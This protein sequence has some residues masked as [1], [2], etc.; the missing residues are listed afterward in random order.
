MVKRLLPHFA[1]V[2][3]FSL[4]T[5]VYFLPYF[6]GMTLNQN[7][8]SQWEGASKEIADWN[9]D[10]PNDPALWTNAM[11]GGMPAVQIS[12]IYPGNLVTKVF[13]TIG[14]P[15]PYSSSYMFLMFIGFYIFCCALM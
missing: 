13:N 7:D 10:H 3:I 15:F 4:L 11:F 5:V 6:Q 9:K 14:V 2:L 12:L 8:V 1:A